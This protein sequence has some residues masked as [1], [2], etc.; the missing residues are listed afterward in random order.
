MWNSGNHLEIALLQYLNSPE[1]V[2]ANRD[3]SLG[4][5]HLF[6]PHSVISRACAA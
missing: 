1:Q 2:A 6:F 5:F 3:L 4:F